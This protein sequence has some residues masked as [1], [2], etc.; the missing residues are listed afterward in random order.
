M[1]ISPS[2]PRDFD[3]PTHPVRHPP[4]TSAY[5]P[6]FTRSFASIY[7]PAAIITLSEAARER[8]RVEREQKS[9]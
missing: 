6:A 4:M 5:A 7:G 8:V 2:L 9:P 1:A 3:P